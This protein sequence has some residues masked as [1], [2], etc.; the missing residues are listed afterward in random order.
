MK[1]EQGKVY[2]S[3]RNGWVKETENSMEFVC[4]KCGRRVVRDAYTYYAFMSAPD[5]SRQCPTCAAEPV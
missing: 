2:E 5:C 3:I 4:S 1:N